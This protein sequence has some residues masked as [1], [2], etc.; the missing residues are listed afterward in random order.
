MFKGCYKSALG[1][2]E[3]KASKDGIT[4][5]QFVDKE[6]NEQNLSSDIDA[7]MEQ[8]DEYFNGDR[9]MFDLSLDMQGTDFQKQVWKKLLKVPYG[10]T[11]S[12]LDIANE[13][14]DSNATRAVGNAN[15]KNQIAIVIPCHR[16]VGSDGKLTGY[17]SGIE[18]KKWLIEHE[19]GGE[20]L[21]LFN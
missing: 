14:G 21:N 13:I 3:I 9:K 10:K 18:R 4:S 7:A 11:C 17:A 15:G 6:A 2:M 12:Y 16:V 19:K 5:I 1:L 8:L 20:Q